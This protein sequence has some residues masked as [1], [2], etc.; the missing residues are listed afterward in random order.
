MYQLVKS[1][2]SLN[3]VKQILIA[4]LKFWQ[5]FNTVN[6]ICTWLGFINLEIFP[7]FTVFS[8]LGATFNKEEEWEKFS[9]FKQKKNIFDFLACCC[10]NYGWLSILKY[11]KSSKSYGCV[12]LWREYSF[13]KNANTLNTAKKGILKVLSFCFM[14]ILI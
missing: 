12:H 11:S 13:K 3:K 5:F 14:I 7:Y 4:T 6:N 10:T 8:N 1:Y 2:K 9:N